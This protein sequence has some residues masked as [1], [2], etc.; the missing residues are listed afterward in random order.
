MTAAQYWQIRALSEQRQREVSD[1]LV[2]ELRAQ[3]EAAKTAQRLSVLVSHLKAAGVIDLT[4]GEWAPDDEK[5]AFVQVN[6]PSQ[7]AAVK[8]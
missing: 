4:V 6:Q 8:P 3:R 2:A 7:D 1:G 5:E